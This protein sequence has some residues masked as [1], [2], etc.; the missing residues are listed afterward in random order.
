MLSSET[1]TLEEVAAALGRSTDWLK[2]NWLRI[3]QE[4][5]FPRKISLGWVW[6]RR[7]VEAWLR[8]GGMFPTGFVAANDDMPV[9]DMHQNLLLEAKEILRRRYGGEA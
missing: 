4:Q 7:Q 3:H 2:R 6:P 8:A 9:I 1:A 5:G